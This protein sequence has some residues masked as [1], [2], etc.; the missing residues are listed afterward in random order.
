MVLVEK[1][2]KQVATAPHQRLSPTQAQDPT[3]Q[4]VEGEQVC[5]QGSWERQ[6]EWR[7]TPRPGAQHPQVPSPSFR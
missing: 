7:L 5:H 1:L 4:A 2:T 6:R 3:L